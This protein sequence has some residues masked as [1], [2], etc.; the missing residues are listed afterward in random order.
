MQQLK[1]YR[2]AQWY[3]DW[4]R[5]NRQSKMADAEQDIIYTCLGEFSHAPGHLLMCEFGTWKLSGMHD[6]DNFE[7]LEKH[8]GDFS[9]TL[10]MEEDDDE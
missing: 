10:E 1:L 8:P 7:E 4:L 5:E 2:R 6:I 3:L 9:I